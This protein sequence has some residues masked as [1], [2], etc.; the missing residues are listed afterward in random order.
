VNSLFRVLNFI[1]YSFKAG[2]EHAVHSPFLFYFYITAI[3]TQKQFY[4]FEAIEK[5]RNKALLIKNN[6]L[7]SDL[8]AGSSTM[9]GHKRCISDIAKTSTKNAKISQLLFR[10][11]WLSKSKNILEL[12][13]SLGFTTSYMASVNSSSKVVTL[14][15]CPE[16]SKFA[17][18]N[19]D[20][21][22]LKNI[23]LINGPIENTLEESLRVLKKVDFA[24]IDA[25]HRYEPTIKYFHQILPFVH[26]ESIL[27][28]DDIYW[29]VEMKQAWEAIKN[30]HQVTISIDLY[31]CGILFFRTNAPKQ[32]YILKI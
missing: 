32:H 3:Y 25:N 20:K 13:T 11:I 9:K 15:G 4:C 28:F 29:S 14:E 27:V 12:G 16:I 26:D 1:K 5:L 19:F 7:V 17:Q 8:G 18:Q 24:F 6:I 23:S 2:D 10:L 31:H 30:H 22:N 21:L